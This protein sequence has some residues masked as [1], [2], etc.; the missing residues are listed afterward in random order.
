MCADAELHSLEL[1]TFGPVFH[2]HL[3]V[4][5]LQQQANLYMWKFLLIY[6]CPCRYVA[7][8]KFI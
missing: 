6:T 1:F 4:F 3:S 2:E 5:D 7:V 8:Q